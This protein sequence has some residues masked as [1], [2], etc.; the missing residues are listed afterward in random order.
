MED[1]KENALQYVAVLRE[2]KVRSQ[3]LSEMRA[4]KKRLREVISRL[5]RE[6]DMDDATLPE[7][8]TTISR[9]SRRRLQP[10]KRSSVEAWAAQLFG[11]NERAGEE[12]G[13]LYDE[14]GVSITEDLTVTQA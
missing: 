2:E 14:R 7:E 4:Q 1:L 6:N 8:G 10:L 3:A 13:K 9:R 11:S 5:M 12:V